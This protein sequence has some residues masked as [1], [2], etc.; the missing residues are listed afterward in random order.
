MIDKL[1]Q[2]NSKGISCYYRNQDIKYT[3]FTLFQNYT[4]I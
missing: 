3:N 4:R 1:Y 2:L